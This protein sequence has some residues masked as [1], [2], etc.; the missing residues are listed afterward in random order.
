MPD[1]NYSAIAIGGNLDLSTTSTGSATTF[2]ATGSFRVYI[3]NPNANVLVDRP[4]ISV[5]AFR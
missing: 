1:V 4:D 2:R 5:A 3:A